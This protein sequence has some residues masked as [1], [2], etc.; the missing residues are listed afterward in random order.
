MMPS[1]SM[2]VRA[3]QLAELAALAHQQLCAPQVA[4]LIAQAK[5]EKL[6]T[7][8]AANLREMQQAYAHATAVPES[9]VSEFTR[10]T[11]AC[12]HVWRE[13]RA[14]NDYA[15]FVPYFTEVLK[16]VCEMAQAKAQALEL[17]PY[18]AL[19]DSYDPGMRYATIQQL[20]APLEA[21]LPG[22][23]DE[24][25]GQRSPE[26]PAL[27]NH[28]VPLAQQ[29]ALGLKMMRQ[30]GFDF[31]TGR[32]DVSA[33]P[34]CGGVPGDI[35]LT[36]RYTENDPFESLYAVLHETGHAL[37]EA[38][39]PAG[40]CQQPVG[41]ARGMS[42]HESQSLFMEMQICRDESFICFLSPLLRESYSISNSNEDILSAL[43]HVERSLI[44][45]NADELT[46]P[47]HILLRTKLEQALLYG[48]LAVKDL[49]GAWDDEMQT[50]LGIRP[51][52]VG[53]GC[54]Q[55]THWPGG[56]IGYFPTYT[57][58]AMIAA[59]LKS[60]MAMDIPDWRTQVASG[61][62]AAMIGWLRDKVHGRASLLSTQEL[63]LQAT[64]K[65]L[66]AADYLEHLRGRYIGL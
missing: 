18:D 35:R 25:V 54:L 32:I 26:R 56:A 10:A 5:D 53:N 21:E 11:T 37:Y 41:K 22:M 50:L 29:E 4:E 38:G 2:E 7:W 6:E 60:A 42:L 61:E 66:S 27:L 8:Q 48:D 14:K 19:L 57:V 52:G 16:L 33:H 55:D 13:V 23:I 3:G 30:L 49:P 43:H 59:Q 62:F 17:S 44:R 40:W 46:Y 47:L 65:P 9:L 24:A 39:L 31:T 63:V 64:G 15:A 20:F 1:G 34:F 36:T 12:E 51:D 45:V 28:A 58:G